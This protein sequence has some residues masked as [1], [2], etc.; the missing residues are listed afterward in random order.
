MPTV[1]LFFLG[2]PRIERDGRIV[3]SD[4]R[5][6]TAL[7]AYLALSGERPSRDFL[8]AFLWPD[9]D[10]SHAKAA[11]RRTLSALKTA[12]GPTT[13][14]ANRES[15][16]L[17]PD[18]VWCDVI[19]FRQTIET[20]D[21]ETAVSLY[22]DDFLT[23]FTL[24]DSLPFDD[25]QLAQTEHWRRELSGALAQLVGR[26]QAQHDWPAG[27]AAARRW[28]QLDPLREEAQRQLMALLAWSGQRSAA[29][30]QYRACVGILEAELGVAPLAE[31]TALYEAIQNNCLPP[32]APPA[33]PE[34]PD[35][36]PPPMA[37]SPPPLPLVGR[38]VELA[39]LA[40][41]YA[42]TGGP[43][44]PNGRFLVLTGEAGI[45]KTR[46]ADTFLAGLPQT[47]RLTA[48]CYEGET[49]LAYAPFTLALREALQHSDAAPRL[50]TVAV[51]WLAE[52]ARLLPEL[53]DWFPDLPAPPPLDWPGAPG[54][55][56][57]GM[58]QVIAA[59]LTGDTPGIL[60][61][62]DGQWADAASL[63][64]LAFLVRRW[65]ERPFLI[66]VCWREG[67]LPADHQLHHLLAE[68]R[69]DGRGAQIILG[70]LTETAVA[71]L[72]NAHNTNATLPYPPEFAQRLYQETEGLPFLLI[73]YLQAQAAQADDR[74][75]LPATV[76]DLFQ[77]RLSQIGETGRQVLQAAAV[78]GRAFDFELL[79]AASGRSEEE[80][81][82]ALEALVGQNLLSE[83]AEQP[84]YDF[85]HHKLRE[86][87]VG[88]MSLT[89]RRLLHRRVAQSLRSQHAALPG[90]LA[91]AVAFHL[92]AAGQEAEAALLFRQAGDHART[93]F[94][95][96]EALAHYQAAL[97]LGHGETAVLHEACG[98]LHTRLG[99]YAAALTSYQQAAAASA[100]LQPH[101]DHKIGQVYYRRGAW[102][103]A[104]RH[105]EQA[106]AG[107]TT[108][109]AATGLAQLYS[110]WATTAYRAGDMTLAARLTQQAQTLAADP[111]TQAQTANMGGMLARKRGDHAEALAQFSRALQLA[112]SQG[113]LAVQIAALNNLGLLETA[114][115]D[116]SRAQEL[117]ESALH[118]C[119]TYGD[120]H[121]EAA[122]RNNLA[123]LLHRSGQGEA[124]MA[125][126]KQ[127]VTIYAEIG[128]ETGDWQPEIWKLSEW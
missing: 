72:V 106:E 41:A 48:R 20:G 125:Q 27:V 105:F 35:T 118:H 67:E 61:L 60:W 73:S 54:R 80:A 90:E 5:K 66:L 38:A 33:L 51:N 116:L 82:P 81:L 44:G 46:L 117:L 16:G 77:S 39:A 24:R 113:D 11:L 50:Q 79:L 101:L 37:V 87:L 68:T 124:A 98:D 85:C 3:D 23:G 21:L 15:I 58:A 103:L 6:A 71:E 75:T 49:S 114:V 89:R 122:L 52:A 107:W 32:P 128:Q 9:F 126:L 112:E 42:N 96:R 45:G 40:Q 62:D 28:L 1:R 102:A 127:A 14:F 97:A 57:E 30:Q 13:I 59:L 100:Q 65:R 119:L 2:P 10:D 56:L 31:T 84:L 69:R 91:G 17:E 109:R 93:L 47:P 121:W 25:W 95:H 36:T 63:D 111:I 76:R 104:E 43:I 123:D 19:Q 8:A 92:Q 55:F 78:I 34:V 12:V 83:Q 4:T 94:A 74:W 115:G 120:R 26:Y 7:L 29:L 22:R 110:D 18:A 108:G 88:E 99:A 53:A 70:R 64:L 86:L